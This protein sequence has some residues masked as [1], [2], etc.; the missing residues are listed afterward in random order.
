MRLSVA[1][2]WDPRLL[3]SLK[4]IP[5][6]HSVYAKSD[7]D[8]IGGGRPSYLLPKVDRQY[9]REYVNHTHKNRMKF[10][11]L[12]NSQCLDN[13]EYTAEFQKKIIDELEWLSD[14]GVDYVTVSIP[15]LLQIIKKRFPALKVFV[16][17]FA[18]INSVQRAVFYRELGADVI[19]LPEYVN[20]DFKLLKQIRECVSCEI[21]LIANMTCLFG[22]PYQLYHANIVSHASQAWHSSKGFYLDYC[23]LKCTRKKISEP[24]ELIKSRWIRPEDTH[25]YEK[26]GI[27][28]FKIIERFDST[29]TLT[30]TVRAYIRQRYGGNL[31]DILNIKT[32]SEKQ[33]PVDVQYFLQPDFADIRKLQ[34]MEDTLYLSGQYIDNRALDGFLEFFKNKNCYASACD[35]C[36]YCR[37]I[38]RKAVTIDPEKTAVS[39]AKIDKKL[40]DL[41][42]GDMFDIA[43]KEKEETHKDIHWDE[44]VRD[45]F[46]EMIHAVPS[47]FRDISWR[48]VSR[49]AESY[50][51]ERYSIVV[52]E[53][54]MVRAFISETPG[55]FQSEMMK[56]LKRLVP[57]VEKYL[58]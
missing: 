46:Q 11:Y 43:P 6:I 2:N 22:C 45:V 51:K 55:A 4:G 49:K 8:M 7:R 12:M 34:D 56:D 38:A 13:L 48:V 10:V 5:G 50:A 42:G 44:T 21:Q 53:G 15:Y 17:V 57:N 32:R 23:I 31:A 19:T 58:P 3:D 9:V 47:E 25:I 30:R 16:S 33:L 20:R 39:L 29:E 36:G 54:D 28:S 24:E 52:E 1:A 41:V 14:I 40:N 35:E 37:Q 18:N 26:I 27:D